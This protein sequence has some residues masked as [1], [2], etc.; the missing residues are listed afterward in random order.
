[1]EELSILVANNNHKWSNISF[2]ADN[3]IFN[4]QNKF[5]SS[6]IKDIL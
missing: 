2:V 4:D 6:I 3:L 5:L 1:M